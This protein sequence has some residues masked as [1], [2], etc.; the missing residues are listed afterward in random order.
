MASC[1]QR[2]ATRPWRS[3]PG[4][5]CEL[6]LRLC[7]EIAGVVALVQLARGLAPGAVDH[8]PALHSRALGD[9]VGPALH[10]LVC[11]DLKEFARTIQQA[12]REAAIPGPHRDVRDGIIV[13][14][15]IFVVWKAAV[16]HVEL[17]LYLHRESIDRVS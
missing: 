10:V 11:L 7:V 5:A 1:C 9:R 15:E 16:K 12:L 4:G 6:V 13:A 3:R 8:A 14:C 2:N 17:A